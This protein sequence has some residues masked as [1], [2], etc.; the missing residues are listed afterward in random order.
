MKIER[1]TKIRVDIQDTLSPQFS[2]CKDYSLHN[3]KHRCM[4][5]GNLTL[6]SEFSY[7]IGF[8]PLSP[9]HIFMALKMD[10]KLRIKY[11]NVLYLQ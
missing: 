3:K 9:I 5:I 2:L 10:I 11:F 4:R 6:K 1:A 7:V 8:R